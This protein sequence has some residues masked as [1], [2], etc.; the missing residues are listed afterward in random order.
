MTKNS[1]N[2]AIF[3]ALSK[4][5]LPDL[6]RLIEKGLASGHDWQG[7]NVNIA[8]Q[9]V[10]LF[11]WDLVRSLLPR[12]SLIL[13]ESGW[14]RSLRESRP[15]NV[16]GDPVPW[17]TYPAIDFLD[18]MT[19]S[20]MRVFEWGSGT[21]T[22]WWSRRIQSIFSVEDHAEWYR[23]M[24]PVLP[25]NATIIFAEEGRYVH[26]IEAVGGDFDIIVIDGSYRDSCFEKA[27]DFVKADGLI[28]FDNSDRGEHNDLFVRAK[29]SG[30]NRLDFWGLTPSYHYKN[31]TS[32]LF[33][34]V[35]AIQ[36]RNV[37]SAHQASAG[38]SCSQA[39]ERI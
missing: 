17:F 20:S 22:I 39:L 34:D 8:N 10:E 26:A 35:S 1:L 31:C 9:M 33:R 12:G 30:W 27:K 4:R 23:S 38:L 18:D 5:D 29:A 36:C 13:H 37:P 28:I 2:Q 15:V 25:S 7:L 11:P 16:Q 6:L 14:V 24:K 3:S 19:H 21:S 32:V